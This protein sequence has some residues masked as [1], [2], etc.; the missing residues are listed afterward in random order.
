MTNYNSPHYTFFS[1]VFSSSPAALTPQSVQQVRSVGSCTWLAVPVAVPEASVLQADFFRGALGNGPSHSSPKPKANQPAYSMEECSCGVLPWLNVWGKSI[2][3]F[4][5]F[6]FGFA[7]SCRHWHQE[8]SYSL[9][10][11]WWALMKK[12][13]NLLHVLST[14]LCSTFHSLPPLTGCVSMVQ[15]F[16]ISSLQ[17]Q[18]YWEKPIIAAQF[19]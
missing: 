12:K 7:L 17:V 6:F 1:V 11:K 5:F 16:S 18:K 2:I 13:L 15:A 10:E 3:F 14:F 19:C 9:P 8:Y 4:F